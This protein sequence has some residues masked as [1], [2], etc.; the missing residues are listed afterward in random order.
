MPSTAH[1]SSRASIPS[2]TI[3]RSSND[4]ARATAGASASQL[5]TFVTPTEEPPH[6][7]LTKSGSAKPFSGSRRARPAA[8]SREETTANFTVGMPASR[9]SAFVT[10]LSIPIAEP[11]TPAPT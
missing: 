4:S 10:A 1:S 11:V 2:S 3:A 9:S 6:D 5:L 8:S 7:G